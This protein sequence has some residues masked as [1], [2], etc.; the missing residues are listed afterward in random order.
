[1]RAAIALIAAAMV[2]SCYATDEETAPALES[3]LRWI[4]I[5]VDALDTARAIAPIDSVEVAGNIALVRFDERD[6]P[7]LSRAMHEQHN[8]CA[9]FIVH[10]TYEEGQLA[11]AA[12]NRDRTADFAPAY[13]IDNAAAVNRLLPALSESSLLMMIQQLSENY[14][15]RYYNTSGGL[16]VPMWLRDQWAGYAA[17]RPDV[18]VE[19]FTHQGFEQR[20]VIATI[21]GSTKPNEVIVIGAHI[22]SIASGSSTAPGADDD[23]SGIATISEVLHALMAKK[24]RPERTV[25]LMAYA[26][27][28]IGLKGSKSIVADYVAKGINVVGV[29]QF[30]MTNYKGSPKDIYLMQDFTN[31]A[32]NT[33]VGNLIDTYVGATWG[34]SQCGYGC[35]DHAS[36]HNAGFAASMPAEATFEDTN[37]N[38]H[39]PNDTL[40]ASNNTATH[41]LKFARLATAYIAELAK[42]ELMNAAPVVSIT[43]PGAGETLTGS[44]PI[45]L[46]ATAMDDEDGELSA[47]IEWTSSLD[48][49]LGSGASLKAKLSAGV[50]TITATAKDSAGAT[51]EATMSLT[52]TVGDGDDDGGTSSG[53][54]AGGGSGLAAACASLLAALRRRRR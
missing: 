33:F 4:S 31:A 29:M 8:R 22:D 21:T 17:D 9:G 25:K 24:F 6:L 28:E 32:Q 39:T 14:T 1:M 44:T 40:E 35:S 20:S 26:A 23:A 12:A 51:G 43:A 2:A 37:P 47:S 42:G 18:T 52:I 48:G 30:D 27:E 38:L 49:A 7:S 11:L 15:S 13:T 54:D 53:C 34:T 5:D 16:A 10:D 19:L 3:Q 41:A 45:E 50:H 36:W 46:D